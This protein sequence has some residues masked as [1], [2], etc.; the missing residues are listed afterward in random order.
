MK[1]EN[2][3]E[4]QTR[5]IKYYV[6]SFC[7]P[8]MCFTKT[9]AMIMSHT[10]EASSHNST[11]C[12]TIIQLMWPNSITCNCQAAKYNLNAVIVPCWYRHIHLSRNFRIWQKANMSK[13]FWSPIW[14]FV[15]CKFIWI[16][17]SKLRYTGSKTRFLGLIS[18]NIR[19]SVALIK[20]LN[21][22]CDIRQDKDC[23]FFFNE[24]RLLQSLR[25]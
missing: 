10:F 5:L 6:S 1:F 3:Q 19:W 4:N 9:V 16:T 17:N 23:I 2:W 18:V 15:T 13:S 25:V 21:F 24:P 8:C 7:N 11:K 14:I 12:T 22:I 20:L